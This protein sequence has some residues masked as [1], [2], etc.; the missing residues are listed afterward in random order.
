[1]GKHGIL[2]MEIKV[3]LIECGIYKALE[4][5]KFMFLYLYTCVGVYKLNIDFVSLFI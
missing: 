2:T 1:M 4:L 5:T 3:D